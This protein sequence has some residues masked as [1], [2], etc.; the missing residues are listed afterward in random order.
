MDGTLLGADS[1]VST[2]SAEIIS[3]LSRRGVAVTVATARTPATVDILLADT[4]TDI[5]AI[6]MTGAALWDRHSRSYIHPVLL[7]VEV[8]AQV[9]GIFSEFTLTPFIYV[10]GDSGRLNVYHRGEM[11]RWEDNFYQERRH[12]SG[13]RFIF[14]H[15]EETVRPPVGTI[16][17]FGMG[18]AE[19]VEAVAARLREVAGLSVSCYRDIFNRNVANIEVFAEGVS[20]ASAIR[21]LAD[22]IGADRVTVYGDNLNDLPMFEVA[23]EAVAVANAMPEVLERA[24]RVIGPNTASSVAR[25]ILRQVENSCE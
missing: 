25:D 16:L 14:G 23:D 5:P 11:N 2:E 6:V 20:K 24:D 22:H 4:I 7:D 1:R 13:K 15:R 12:L 9:I 19:R 18:E 3:D 8:A 17:I 10:L 21:R